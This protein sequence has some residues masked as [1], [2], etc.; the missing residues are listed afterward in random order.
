MVGGYASLFTFI[1]LAVHTI[2]NWKTEVSDVVV[3]RGGSWLGILIVYPLVTI[4]SLLHSLNYYVLMS[5]INNVAVGIMQSL[6]AVLVF[7][8]SHYLFCSVSSTQCFNE[9]KFVSAIV[10]IG[11]VT[12]FSFSSNDEDKINKNKGKESNASVDLTLPA[13]RPSGPAQRA[14]SR[15]SLSIPS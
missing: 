1:Y 11:F 9:W 6:R 3:N 15:L 2:P 7:V 8:M 10:V 5:R 12:M 13:N 14:N 4:S